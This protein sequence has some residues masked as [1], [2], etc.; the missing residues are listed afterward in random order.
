M[1]N[2][3]RLNE[4]N[5]ANSLDMNG[6]YDSEA[7][8]AKMLSDE[9]CLSLELPRSLTPEQRNQAKLVAKQHP[10]LKC[11]SYGFGED[12]RLHVFKRSATTCVKVKNTF[13]DGFVMDCNDG[14][15]ADAIIFRSDPGFLRKRKPLVSIGN[16]G[17]GKLE[18]PPLPL[19]YE[20]SQTSSEPS[21]PV[22]PGGAREDPPEFP[23]GVFDTIAPGTWVVI[24]G[25]AKAPD[26]N[27]CVGVAHSLDPVSGRYDVLLASQASG[28]RW[29]KVKYGNLRPTREEHKHLV[30]AAA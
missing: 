8:I 5:N 21:P 25:L 23:P 28:R 14:D 12:R 3:G 11:E 20:S 4:Q 18:L 22:T 19:H 10:E 27:G 16:L 17:E 7:A 6:N 15:K 26:F 9:G 30:S 13:V 29:A 1:V 2:Q 24:Q